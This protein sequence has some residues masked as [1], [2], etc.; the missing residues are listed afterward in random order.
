MSKRFSVRFV[1]L[2]ILFLFQSF[3]NVDCRS[4]LHSN[5]SGQ[6]PANITI[7]E[8]RL[9]ELND[10]AQRYDTRGTNIQLSEKEVSEVLTQ[11]KI[12]YRSELEIRLVYL[13]RLNA[14]RTKV[15]EKLTSLYLFQQSDDLAELNPESIRKLLYSI[16]L[17]T[18]IRRFDAD[19][20]LVLKRI[21]QNITRIS[22]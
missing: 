14:L 15:V 8:Q 2:S 3:A 7:L 1:L 12:T 5:S 19:S 21:S 20:L 17:H 6:I 16:I 9:T 10:E 13:A 11:E 22:S 4:H 18:K